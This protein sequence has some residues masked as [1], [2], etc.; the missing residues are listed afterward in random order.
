MV[1]KETR[2]RI[3]NGSDGFKEIIPIIGL[4]YFIPGVCFRCDSFAVF[5]KSKSDFLAQN[6]SL[7]VEKIKQL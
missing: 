7:K 3:W 1:H 4:T 5:V 6:L 2:F